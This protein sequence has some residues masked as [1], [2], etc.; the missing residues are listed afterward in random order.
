MTEISVIDRK[1]TRKRCVLITN[2]RGWWW[3]FG[4]GGFLAKLSAI[5]NA[6]TTLM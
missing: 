6:S 3:G 1:R 5:T 4:V 2:D